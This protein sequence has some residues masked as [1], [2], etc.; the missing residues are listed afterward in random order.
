[1]IDVVVSPVDHNK[2][3]PEVV[4]NELPQLSVTLTTGADGIAIGAAV[5]VPTALVHPLTVCVTV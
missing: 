3:L 4:N 2:L 1:M 5:P